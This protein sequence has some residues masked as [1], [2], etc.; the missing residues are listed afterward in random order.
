M[1]GVFS[2]GVSSRIAAVVAASVGV[3]SLSGVAIGAY[4][5][6]SAPATIESV[7]AINAKQSAED[8]VPN[9]VDLNDFGHSGL[10]AGSTRYLGA[11]PDA[12]YYVALD[13]VGFVCAIVVL[14]NSSM[15]ASSCATDSDIRSGGLGMSAYDGVIGSEVAFFLLPDGAVVTDQAS[16]T[17]VSRNIVRI[18]PGGSL[19]ATMSDKK[20]E[21][22]TPPKL[23]G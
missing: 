5:A 23:A 8:K 16:V 19:V 12:S 21:L 22:S 7:S 20:S 14:A 13:K 10:I 9:S 6:A 1:M 11:D 2:N 3:L 15:V 17:V 18:A 4:A